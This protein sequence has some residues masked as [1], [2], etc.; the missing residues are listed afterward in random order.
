MYKIEKQ[1]NIWL[2]ILIGLFILFA[3]TQTLKFFLKEPPMRINGELVKVANEINKHVPIVVD[4]MVSL[5]NVD[6]LHGD[7]FQ[8]NYSVRA[9]KS[10]LDTSTLAILAKQDLL[11]Q[12]KNNDKT[13][14]FKEHNIILQA[15][16]RDSNNTEIFRVSILPSEY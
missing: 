13:E 5:D 6:A 2:R 11:E 1:K 15:I 8:Y 7:I 10:E 14:V 16:Y 9:E 12:F 4:S 3:I